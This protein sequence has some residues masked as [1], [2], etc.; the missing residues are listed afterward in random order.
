[1][2]YDAFL[3]DLDGTLINTQ[4]VDFLIHRELL[5]AFGYELTQS[6][7]ASVFGQTRPEMIKNLLHG[8]GDPCNLETYMEHYVPRLESDLRTHS[9]LLVTGAVELCKSFYIHGIPIALV[10]SSPRSVLAHIT[11]LE[12]LLPLFSTTIT[13]DDVTN[14]KPHPEPFLKAS[15]TLDVMHPFIFEDS[16][17]GI[18]AANRAGIPF[19]THRHSANTSALNIAQTLPRFQFAFDDYNAPQIQE[20]LEQIP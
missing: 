2:L 17:P 14:R 11:N 7:Y 10:T 9:T 16:L 3:F 4:S 15:S 8:A 5:G 18:L 6:T 19:A 20:F 13:A 1:M 12:P